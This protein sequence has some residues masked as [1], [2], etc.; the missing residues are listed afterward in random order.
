M[1][2]I[3]TLEIN[4]L[5]TE[6][7]LSIEALIESFKKLVSLDDSKDILSIEMKKLRIMQLIE[8]H[9]KKEKSLQCATIIEP[10]EVN[11]TSFNLICKR[12]FY[13]FLLVFGLFQDASSTY[14]FGYALIALIPGISNLVL[15]PLSILF[16]ALECVLFY[17]F[18]VS[19]L[20]SA[21]GI[22]HEETD[23]SLLIDTYSEQLKTTFKLLSII[24][25]VTID[26]DRYEDIMKFVDLLH[27]DQLKKHF[28]I[29][30]HKEP[31]WKKVLNYSVTSF[32]A[33]SSIAGSYFMA[34]AFLTVWAASLMA[35]PVGIV[36]IL[37]TMVSGLGFYYAMGATSM[38]RLVNPNHDKFVALKTEFTVFQDGYENNVSQ[39]QAMKTQFENFKRKTA[40]LNDEP[41]PITAAANTPA[42]IGL[43]FFSPDVKKAEPKSS[44][45][46]SEFIFD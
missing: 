30:A 26:D 3:T 4:V 32:G 25:I 18:E 22:P 9:I 8:Q 19:L 23:I 13:Y 20:K 42:Q 46:T 24:P 40:L 14:L 31:M 21:L 44:N 17:A 45:H 10:K 12:L 39:I 11:T 15:I 34:N 28:L 29:N 2:L 16:T 7:N 1:P 33:L 5:A 36:I 38:Q 6:E 37:L 41:N 43:L 35:S 27:A